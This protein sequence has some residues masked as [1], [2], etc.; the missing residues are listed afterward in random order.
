M[1]VEC[2][3]C[4]KIYTLQDRDNPEDYV[5]ECGGELQKTPTLGE[6][7][8]GLLI[9]FVLQFFLGIFWELLPFGIIAVIILWS[10]KD[11]PRSETTLIQKIFVALVLMYILL[12]SL[13]VLI[14]GL[15][16]IWSSL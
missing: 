12:I 11:T 4:G 16:S 14:A 7:I 1:K 6:L 9:A 15:A 5:C 13:C 2:E 10:E 8:P 3:K